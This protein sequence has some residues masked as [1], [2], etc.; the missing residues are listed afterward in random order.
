[1]N[2]QTLIGDKVLN[3]PRLSNRRTE[4]VKNYLLSTLPSFEESVRLHQSSESCSQSLQN[5]PAGQF[6]L[7]AYGRANA[8]YCA[9][10]LSVLGDYLDIQHYS[11]VL[12]TLLSLKP[13]TV[14]KT[15]YPR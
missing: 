8:P 7:D 11:P 1:M 13:T 15:T 5:T 3:Q 9:I 4:L 12:D 6:R 10:D 2:T 14:L